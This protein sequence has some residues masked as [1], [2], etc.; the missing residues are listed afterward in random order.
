MIS[1][2]LGIHGSAQNLQKN[3]TQKPTPNFPNLLGS[4]L[5]GLIPIALVASP[6]RAAERIKFAL[7]PLDLGVSIQEL[8]TFAKEG[9]VGDELDFY[10]SRLSSND[11]RKYIREYL[12]FK[13]DV[14][15]VHISQF[16]YSAIGVQLLDFM[17][18]HIL[19]GNTENGSIAIRAA[20]ILAASDPEGLTVIN[21]LKKFPTTEIRLN[22]DLIFATAAKVE[23]FSKQTNSAIATI[24][25]LSLQQAKTEPPINVEQLQA[26]GFGQPGKFTYKVETTT[27]K[28]RSRNRTLVVDFYLPQGLTSPA[29]VIVLSHG[30][31]SNRL[32]FAALAKHFASYGYVA[33]VPQHSGSDIVYLE[34]FLKGF[35]QEIF[36]VNEFIDRP[37]D[38]RFI[39][40]EM[41]RRF[42]NQVNLEKV[43]VVGHSFGGYTAF[44]VAGATID[45]GRLAKEC[46]NGF[47]GTNASLLV[48]CEALK[49]PQKEYN[50]RDDRVKVAIVI[51]PIDS[52]ILGPEGLGQIKIP[53]VVFAASEDTVAPILLEQVQP[54]TWLKSPERYLLLGKGVGHVFDVRSL[55]QTLAPSVNLFVPSKDIESLRDYGRTFFL[56]LLETH[57]RDRTDF[58]SYLLA[59][60]AIGVTKEPTKVFLLNSLAQEQFQT[61]LKAGF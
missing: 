1:R 23:G 59:S 15:A 47:N 35:K 46:A 12:N 40:D 58:G 50:F 19:A 49:L 22:S 25:N 31:A 7:G 2:W 39:L 38:I 61:M 6:V 33:A 20:F 45:F 11:D 24:E 43:A 14:K 56:A 57:L 44:M 53:V 9:K 5:L 51:S 3:T 10:L 28:D 34:Q 18:R 54:F 55:V 36:D 42:P 16:F 37:L 48:Q 26:K 13:A 41:G 29:P 52:D 30:L 27:L 17:G 8:E 60:Y 21:F 32:H 4:V